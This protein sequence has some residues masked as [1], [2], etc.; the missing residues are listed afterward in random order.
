MNQLGLKTEDELQSWFITRLDSFITSK[1]RRMVGWDEI[2]EGGLAPNAV[3]MDPNFKMATVHQ[4]NLTIQRE[5][6]G[7]FVV[8]AAYVANRGERLYSQLD[9]NQISSDFQRLEVVSAA[10][11]QA[12]DAV[13][14]SR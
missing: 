8:Q 3:V 6:P 14:P 9:V 5:L 10:T 7:G 13:G 12:T 4:W 2:L 11:V 1:G